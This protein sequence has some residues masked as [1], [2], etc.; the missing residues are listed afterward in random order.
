MYCVATRW[1]AIPVRIRA[2][3]GGSIL[4]GLVEYDG[5][6][7][8]RVLEQREQDADLRYGVVC[9][10]SV[11][12][13]AARCAG[14]GEVDDGIAQKLD[15]SKQILF[16]LLRERRF[17]GIELES[18]HSQISVQSRG[19]SKYFLN[20]VRST[21]KG[22]VDMARQKMKVGGNRDLKKRDNISWR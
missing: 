20:F 15:V 3:A 8:L 18:G 16:L 11:A 21:A 12:A 9:A 17:C 1:P 19:P 2:I 6:I 7:F 4:T 14:C 22:G 5:H 13:H 10:A